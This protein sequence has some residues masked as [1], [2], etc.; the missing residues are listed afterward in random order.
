MSG[1]YH[2]DAGTTIA[3]T[4][5]QTKPYPNPIHRT[6]FKSV[7]IIWFNKIEVDGDDGVHYTLYDFEQQDHPET[8]TQLSNGM[9]KKGNKVTLTY[10]PLAKPKRGCIKICAIL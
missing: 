2:R 9:P 6:A 1:V 8:R 4:V 7:K 3:G 5:T 10:Y